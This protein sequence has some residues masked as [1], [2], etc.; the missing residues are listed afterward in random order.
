MINSDEQTFACSDVSQV[1]DIP[2]LVKD[3]DVLILAAG[4]EERAFRVL[5]ESRFS[6][7]AHCILLRFVSE[8]A[9]NNALFEKFLKSALEKLPQDRIHIVDLLYVDPQRLAADMASV[10]LKLPRE[11]RRFGLDISGM[12]SHAICSILK[13]VRDFLPEEAVKILYTAARQYVPSKS[14]YEELTKRNGDE[15]ELLPKSMALEMDY[16]L[17][18]DAFSGYR[19]QNA[20][21]CLAIFAGFEVHRSTGVIEAVN[22]SLLL[23]LYGQPGDK[24]LSWRLELSRKLHRKFEKGRRTATEIVSTLLLQDSLRMLE[25]YYNF[26]IDDYDLVISPI[27]SKMHVVAAY[28]FWEKYGEVQLTFPIPIGYNPKNAPKGIGITYEVILQPRRGLFRAA[29]SAISAA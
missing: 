10:L 28:L 16:N 26:I 24:S 12:P 18:L 15:I 9:V 22:P 23:L 3:L 27:G 13:V 2:N 19:S 4:F 25:T 6:T 5:P 21:A 1:R 11:L 20:K 7:N 29:T 8:V 17:V 14:E